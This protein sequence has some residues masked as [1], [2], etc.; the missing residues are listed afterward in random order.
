MSYWIGQSFGVLSTV[1]NISQPL[2][3][4]KWQMLVANMAV[5]VFLLLNLFF[6]GRIGSG[7]FLFL[8]AIVQ[9]A[10]NLIHTL[11]ETP[12]GK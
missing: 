9:S 1:T 8:V 3:R 11:R 10:V 12:P 6:L 2:F 4:K 7:V 5:N